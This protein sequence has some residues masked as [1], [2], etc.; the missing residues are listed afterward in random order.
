MKVRHGQ[1][2]INNNSVFLISINLNAKSINSMIKSQAQITPNISIYVKNI[3]K[4]K[5]IVA[6][7]HDYAM[8]PASNQKILTTI[9]A[10]ELLGPNYQFKTYIYTT[11]KIDESGTLNGHVYVDTKGDPSL[12]TR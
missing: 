7:R 1:K 11:G 4:D 10:L 12:T 6:H 5:V 8:T 2:L 9:T 3:T